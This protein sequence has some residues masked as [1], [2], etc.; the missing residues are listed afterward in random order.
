[1]N[2]TYYLF[3]PYLNYTSGLTRCVLG[4]SGPTNITFTSELDHVLV[5]GQRFFTLFPLA[6]LVNRA[7]GTYYLSIGGARPTNNDEKL[8][9][10]ILSITAVTVVF[11][12][13]LI[14]KM[15]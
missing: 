12:L 6:V 2:A 7:A 5:L 9:V 4:L 10:I 14:Y 1:M 8:L 15:I 13:L 3:E 11:I